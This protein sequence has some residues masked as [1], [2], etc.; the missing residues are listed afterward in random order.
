MVGGKG[1]KG[2]GR[3]EQRRRKEVGQ[4]RASKHYHLYTSDH[5][6]LPTLPGSVIRAAVNPVAVRCCAEPFAV[7]HTL[8]LPPIKMGTS[9]TPLSTNTTTLGILNERWSALVWTH[10]FAG[11]KVEDLWATAD[12]VLATPALAAGWV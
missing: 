10:T 3:V 1:K 5:P 7:S 8:T 4:G 2:G 11:L 12:N 9:G 6:H